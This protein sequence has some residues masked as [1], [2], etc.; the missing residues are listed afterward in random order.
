MWEKAL[1]N[2]E[3]YT[4]R[5]VLAAFCGALLGMG[6]KGKH[7][8]E[9]VLADVLVSTGIALFTILSDIAFK[10]YS[11]LSELLTTP[12][13]FIGVF[14]VM[15]FMRAKEDSGL[16]Y[17]VSIWLAAGMGLASGAGK[18]A[19]AGVAALLVAALQWLMHWLITAREKKRWTMEIQLRPEAEAGA[20]KERLERSLHAEV[21]KFHIVR[22]EDG[23]SVVRITCALPHMMG[24]DD[25]MQWM[26]DCGDVT[27]IQG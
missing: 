7:R 1:V 14:G 11:Y 4:L 5:L 27:E 21:E 26:K 13:V 18:Y 25:A 3:W 24:P 19:L 23:C 20:L 22:R 10:R 8:A 12:L 16:T 17:A 6:C 15:A 9:V 2:I